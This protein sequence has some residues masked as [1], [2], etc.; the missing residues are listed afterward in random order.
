MIR[1]AGATRQSQVHS[2][3]PLI[4]DGHAGPLRI[5]AD[6]TKIR[7]S[8]MSALTA[9]MGYVAFA[10]SL[11]GGVLTATLGTVLFAMGASAL[12]E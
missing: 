4:S 11:D 10:R 7:I 8:S 1:E 6:L 2:P 12:N 9:V 3:L 5:F